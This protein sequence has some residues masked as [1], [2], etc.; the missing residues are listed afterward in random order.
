MDN[1]MLDRLP[2]QSGSRFAL[3]MRYDANAPESSVCAQSGEATVTSTKVRHYLGHRLRDV[4]DH[5]LVA[6][7]GWGR[8]ISF[9]LLQNLM[10]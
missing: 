9:A 10:H 8:G 4:C 3:S 2:E 1:I 5:T 7:A 6:N